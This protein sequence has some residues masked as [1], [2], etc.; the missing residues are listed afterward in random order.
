MYYAADRVPHKYGPIGKMIA[1]ARAYFARL[2][3]RI[4]VTQYCDV[5]IVKIPKPVV[6]RQPYLVFVPWFFKYPM[7]IGLKDGKV[8]IRKLAEA[9]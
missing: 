7:Q 1:G 5:K 2:R 3:R 9:A 4:Y 6:V 8:Q